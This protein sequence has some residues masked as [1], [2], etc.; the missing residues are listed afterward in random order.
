MQ[1]Q[2]FDEGL[3]GLSRRAPFKPFMVELVSGKSFTVDHPDALVFR[4]GVAVF[5]D[6]RG[7]LSIF[8]HESVSR[9]VETPDGEASRAA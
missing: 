5:I 8:D 2:T 4:A 9:L 6:P 3:R 1:A 7:A